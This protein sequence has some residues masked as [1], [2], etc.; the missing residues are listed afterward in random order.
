[1]YAIAWIFHADEIVVLLNGE[2]VDNFGQIAV[3]NRLYGD[4]VLQCLGHAP[5]G[6]LDLVWISEEA[7]QAPEIL[8][9]GTEGNYTTVS[10]DYNVATLTVDNFIRPYRGTLR[11]RAPSSDRQIT[12]YVTDST[13]IEHI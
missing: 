13:W 4:L 12:V 3:V 9:E 8:R 11:C 10:Y 6:V 7:G 2:E 1:M 5:S